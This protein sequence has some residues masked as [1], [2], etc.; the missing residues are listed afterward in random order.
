MKTI[1][2]LCVVTAVFA[3]PARRAKPTKVA[4]DS[5]A[6]MDITPVVP[7]PG[8]PLNSLNPMNQMNPMGPEALP[9]PL[10]QFLA[11]FQ[12]VNQPATL[13]QAAALPITL[14]QF[15]ALFQAVNQPATLAQAAGLLSMCGQAAGQPANLAQAAGIQ[16]ACGQLAA[17]PA[18]P[19]P[20]MGFPGLLGQ[21]LGG[22]N[23]AGLPANINQAAL[24]KLLGLKK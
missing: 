15:L 20:A 8:A 5:S 24:A 2:Y 22:K 7:K 18:T 13:A 17:R 16:A 19:T 21:A 1:I 11:L 4:A 9:I 12:A 14:D 23:I 6:E 3:A 10:D